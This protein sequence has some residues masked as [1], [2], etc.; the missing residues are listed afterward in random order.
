MQN[1]FTKTTF[2]QGIL[3]IKKAPP[4][5]GFEFVLAG[6]SNAGKSSALNCLAKNKKLARTS[7]TPGR[8]TE[9]NFFKVT[10]EV[11]LVDLPG[12]GFSKISVD[13]KKNLDTLLD[14]YFSSRQSLCAAIIFMDIRHP[15]KNS[16]IQMMEFCHKYEV[17]F[18]PVLT[19]SD[20]LNNSAVSRSIKNVEKKLNSK[21]IIVTSSK[22]DKGFDKLSKK[23]LEFVE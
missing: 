9:I 16:D 11:K 21:S 2:M 13:K 14:S 6:R 5:E 4:D 1:I 8:T 7:K 10:D 3:N 15:L 17:P 22:D 20:K 12:Y 18:I 19:K 23:I